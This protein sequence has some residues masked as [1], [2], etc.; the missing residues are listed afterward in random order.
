MKEKHHIRGLLPVLL[1]ILLSAMLHA[2]EFSNWK[3]YTNKKNIRAA[4]I[5]GNTAWAATTGGLFSYNLNQKSYFALN[6]ADGL[7]GSGLNA[8]AIDGYGKIW[9]G[10]IDGMLEIYN[11]ATGVTKK[12]FNIINSGFTNKKINSLSVK[13]DTIFVATEFGLSLINAKTFAFFD[14]FSKFASLNANIKVYSAFK[15]SLIHIAT[16]FGLVEQIPGSTNLSAPSSWKVTSTTGGLSS[17]TVY[18]VLSFQG[19]LTTSGNRGFSQRTGTVWGAFLPQFNNAAITDF[20]VTGDSML[21]ISGNLL[22]LHSNGNTSLLYT[23]TTGVLTSVVGVEN[24]EIILASDNGLILLNSGGASGDIYPPGPGSNQF[25][26]LSFDAGGKMWVATGRDITG[27]GLYTFD[28]TTWQSLTPATNPA[29]ITNAYFNVTAIDDKIFAGNWGSGFLRI[30]GSGIYQNFSA[31]NTPLRGISANPD[32]IVIPSIKSD[33]RGNVWILNH[34][35]ANRKILNVLTPDST[36]HQFANYTDSSLA[37]YMNMLIDRNDTKWFISFDPARSGLYFFNENKTFSVTSDDKYGYASSV[38]ELTGKSINSMV[39]DKRGEI[40]LGTNLGCYV[41]SN[42]A[43]VLNTQPSL[44]VNSL[45]SLRQYTIT[46]MAVDPVNRKWIGTNNSGV[47]VMSPDGTTLIA[48]FNTSNSPLLSNDIQSI[49]VEEQTGIVYIGTEAGLT[50]VQTNAAKPERD[51]GNLKTYPSPFVLSSG[52]SQLTIDGLIQES[53]IKIINLSG[54]LV[55]EFSSPGGRIAQ[56]NG[57]DLSGNLVGTGI[58]ILSA[59]DKEGN[60]ISSVK[61]AVVRK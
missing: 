59:F 19:K 21:F 42:P 3:N 37:Q 1:I 43:S 22:Y 57:R 20:M 61:I 16:D 31:Q 14:T 41:I 2:Q 25:V 52:G 50:S 56:W 23:N 9:M 49:A 15:D 51:F 46:A 40:W 28:G 30:D 45:F 13:S 33:S 29:M 38:S 24:S 54:G 39:L 44:R 27:K 4:S 55:A 17:N 6:K 11:P 12:I 36:W 32:F 7:S 18:K 34:D 60:T 26:D 53:D 47:L 58:Y 48:S 35:A 10:G 8:L 5:R